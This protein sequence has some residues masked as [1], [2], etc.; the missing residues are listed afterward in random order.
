MV[1]YK[2]VGVYSKYCELCHNK[3]QHCLNLQLHTNN[4]QQ[5]LHSNILLPWVVAALMTTFSMP[6]TGHQNHGCLPWE[7]WQQAPA[8]YDGQQ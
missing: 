3:K 5:V 4:Y 6:W 2:L 7:E 1:S 8:K